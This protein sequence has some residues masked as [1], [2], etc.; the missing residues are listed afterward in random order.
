[1]NTPMSPTH[2]FPSTNAPPTPLQRSSLKADPHPHAFTE[3]DLHDIHA[4]LRARDPPQQTDLDHD[5]LRSTYYGRRLYPTF[6]PSYLHA[7]PMRFIRQFEYTA[8]HNNLPVKAWAKRLNACLHGAAA[9]W[10]FDEQ[11]LEVPVMAWEK[12]KR[13][14]L[15]WALL[16]AE[17][18]VRRQR[19]IRFFQTEGDLSSDF[20]KAFEE[21]AVG[22]RDYREDVWVRK[23]VAN[24]RPAVRTALAEMFPEAMPARFRDLRDALYAADWDLYEVASAPLKVAREPSRSSMCSDLRLSGALTPSNTRVRRQTSSPSSSASLGVAELIRML[25][26]LSEKERALVMVALERMS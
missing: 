7:C 22:L 15:D 16:P 17:Q 8:Q 19:L 2:G 24:M 23:C 13:Q 1:M 18:E 4:K 12:R 9:D 11:P 21:H 3:D 5:L 25:T 26:R 20:A 10:A 14:F 6:D